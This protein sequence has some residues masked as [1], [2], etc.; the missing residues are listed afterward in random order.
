MTNP[1]RELS[2]QRPARIWFWAYETLWEGT[3]N[4]SRSWTLKSGPL[5][6]IYLFDPQLLIVP[7]H[8]AKCCPQL[9]GYIRE[10]NTHKSTRSFHLMTV[11]V[12][13]LMQT[14]FGLGGECPL[15]NGWNASIFI[16]ILTQWT[17]R[18][19]SVKSSTGSCIQSGIP[20]TN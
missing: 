15:E 10:Q 16:W 3:Q 8:H 14:E 5:Y 11:W 2:S 18:L 6:C 19:Q 1:G 12:H 4:L 7:L 17:Q 9:C 20:A 13:F